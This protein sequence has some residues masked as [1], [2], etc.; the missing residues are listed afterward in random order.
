MDPVTL[1]MVMKVGSAAF[2]AAGYVG[3]KVISVGLPLA[4]Q[5]GSISLRFIEG[6]VDAVKQGDS[7]PIALT[8]KLD[9]IDNGLN[10]PLSFGENQFKKIDQK[11]SDDL[12]IIK[13]QNEI[14]FLSNS[15]KYFVDSHATRTG[16]DR[17]I[18]YALQ[19]D[20]KAVINHIKKHEGIRFPGYL[21]HQCTSLSETIKEYNIFYDSILNNGYVHE[22]TED[23]AKNALTK[24]FGIDGNQGV[25]ASYIPWEYKI[26]F[27]RKKELKQLKEK[28]QSSWK[29]VFDSAEIEVND[30]AHDA[31]FVL[32][33]ELTDNERLEYSISRKIESFPGNNILIQSPE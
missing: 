13:G 32:A 20:I 24:T 22:W 11:I 18:S 31:L 33:Q 9:I 15:I 2:N 21:L 12:D 7:K 30:E 8:K 29:K 1:G 26:P 27:K 5:A 28:K 6:G 4:K 23:E 3:S 10:L 19:Y 16:I 14:L 17:G 25:V